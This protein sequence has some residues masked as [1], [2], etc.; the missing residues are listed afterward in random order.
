MSEDS[1][2]KVLLLLELSSE[3]LIMDF[4]DFVGLD[5]FYFIHDF[6]LEDEELQEH[7]SDLILHFIQILVPK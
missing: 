5:F 3:S 1:G 7:M 2:G 6:F 4:L